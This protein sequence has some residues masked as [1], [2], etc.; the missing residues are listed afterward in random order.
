MGKRDL[1]DALSVVARAEY[2]LVGSLLQAEPDLCVKLLTDVRCD[3]LL[4]P[5]L[6]AIV[7]AMKECE[8]TSSPISVV[9]V[10]A[11]L[12]KAM[13]RMGGIAW[14]ESVAQ[15]A[16]RKLPPEAALQIV[17]EAS[18]QR[19]L[20]ALLHQV[21]DE[22][23]TGRRVCGDAIRT[24][25]EGLDM[26]ESQAPVQGA[27]QMESLEMCT[28]N[29]IGAIEAASDLA[30]PDGVT[31]IRTACRRWTGNWVVCNEVTWSSWQ[32]AR[33]RARPRSRSTSQTTLERSRSCLW[34]S[35]RWRWA[36]PSWRCG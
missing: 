20:L 2:Q 18:M 25:Y 14:L 24:L 21:Q 12:G 22:V 10:A 35:S 4:E 31:G 11:K 9:T 15:R 36:A 23:A 13:D 26:I 29:A 16:D 32:G 8:E 19:R 1:D 27:G 7:K 34:W 3:D 5:E 30:D 28:S 17:V 33:H 6:R